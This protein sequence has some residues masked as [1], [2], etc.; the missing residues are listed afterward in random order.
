MGIKSRIVKINVY[1]GGLK[2]PTLTSMS[3]Y[4]YA[5][6]MCK[7]VW[8][9]EF[10]LCSKTTLTC[11]IRFKMQNSVTFD[12][13]MFIWVVEHLIDWEY[14]EMIEMLPLPYT[15]DLVSQ[16]RCTIGQN[17]INCC[18]TATCVYTCTYGLSGVKT[19]RLLDSE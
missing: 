2:K 9:N 7:L 11:Q 16:Y 4:F 5:Y 8:I 1:G 13:L 15:W 18:V 3:K 6:F 10:L 14:E 17:W 12:L 19:T